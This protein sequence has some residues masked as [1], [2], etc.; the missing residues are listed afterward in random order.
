MEAHHAHPFRDFQEFVEMICL[1]TKGRTLKPKK[2]DEVNRTFGE[3][4]RIQTTV[5]KNR[6]LQ[7]GRMKKEN[8]KIKK[9]S[10][11]VECK[12]KR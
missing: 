2:S 4:N 11:A 3:K 12:I 7:Q 6:K 10:V 5:E 8:K 9:G 1:L